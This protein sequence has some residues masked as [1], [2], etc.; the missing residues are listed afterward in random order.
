M[1]EWFY[2]EDDQLIEVLLGAAKANESAGPPVW[3]LL[4][5]PPSTGKTTLVEPLGRLPGFFAV[6]ALTSKTFASGLESPRG[7]SVSLLNRLPNPCTLVVKDFS[8]IQAVRPDQKADLLATLRD[9]YDGSY[10][11]VFGNGTEV[12]WRGKLGLIGA[13]TND[14]DRDQ[15]IQAALGERFLHVR[16]MRSNDT[17]MA[18]QALSMGRRETQVA[19]ELS[20]AFGRV[21]YAATD[22]STVTLDETA[23]SELAALAVALARWRTPIARDHHRKVI[24]GPEPE[25][26]GR[27]VKQFQELACGIAAVN[28][29]SVVGDCEIAAVRRVAQDSIPS[30][31]CKLL[32]IL[33]RNEDP[34]AAR[35]LSALVNVPEAT[36]REKL[37]DLEMLEVVRRTTEKGSVT[38]T[39][40]ADWSQALILPW[41]YEQA[42]THNG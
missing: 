19:E 23:R 39:A 17:E 42:K 37:E 40:N 30:L 7:A 25:G 21:L 12:S 22:P 3:L 34:M 18:L 9:I 15:S 28:G 8:P 27:L 1:Q 16:M 24:Y 33:A 38:W 5:A 4:V 32:R 20:A 14:I 2:L 10:R 36:L 29:G 35:V 41:R 26:P 11:K 6:S 31:R 13:A